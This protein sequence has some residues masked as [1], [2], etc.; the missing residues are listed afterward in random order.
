VPH[1]RWVVLIVGKFQCEQIA[2]IEEN[3]SH[4]WVR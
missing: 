3:R 2:G 4:G 1:S